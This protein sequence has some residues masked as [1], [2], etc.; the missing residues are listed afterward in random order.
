M[1]GPEGLLVTL[2]RLVGN[3]SVPLHIAT[4]V[5]AG[6][7]L[8]LMIL[9]VA[10]AKS[11]YAGIEPEFSDDDMNA[12]ITEEDRLL[13]RATSF[14]ASAAMSLSGCMLVDWPGTVAHAF[15]GPVLLL[16][17]A[18]LGIPVDQDAAEER[19]WVCPR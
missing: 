13:S 6:E 4:A 14:V 1:P 3:V 17:Q 18:W 11:K 8:R 7:P 16:R 2:N 10:A 12:T 15:V 9:Q 19:I 5:N